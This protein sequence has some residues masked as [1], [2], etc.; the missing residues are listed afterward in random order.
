VTPARRGGIGGRLLETALA[1][2]RAAGVD[3]VLLWP[4]ARSR[5]LYERYGFGVRDDLLALRPV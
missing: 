3:A 4:C 5:S 2:C 1:W